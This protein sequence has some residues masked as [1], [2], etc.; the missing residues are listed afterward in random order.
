MFVYG[1]MAKFSDK[2]IGTYPIASGQQLKAK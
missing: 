2:V 1:S